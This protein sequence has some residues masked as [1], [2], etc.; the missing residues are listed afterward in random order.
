MRRAWGN[1]MVC[2]LW[3]GRLGND[4]GCFQSVPQLGFF[5]RKKG[6]PEFV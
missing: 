6:E 2:V 4:D 1:L 5:T 3:E